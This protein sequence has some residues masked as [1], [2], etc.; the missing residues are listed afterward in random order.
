M[1]GKIRIYLYVYIS[2]YVYIY[3]YVYTHTRIYILR[4]ATTCTLAELASL[5]E[6]IKEWQVQ[7]Q[8]H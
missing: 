7:T 3:I 6:V 2:M 1:A 8:S 4:L 5:E